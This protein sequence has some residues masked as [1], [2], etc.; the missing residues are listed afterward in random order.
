MPSSTRAHADERRSLERE[1]EHLEVGDAEAPPELGG[2]GGQLARGR[3]V[4]ARVGEVALVEREPAVVG[5]GSSGSSRRCARR[6]QP[7]ATAQAPRKSSSSA[8][9]HVAMR[10]APAASAALP[11][12]PVRALPGGEHGLGVVEPPGRPAQPLERLGRLLAGDG[13]L[14]PRPRGLPAPRAQFAPTR[15]HWIGRPVVPCPAH[16]DRILPRASDHTAIRGTL[17]AARPDAP[18]V[19]QVRDPAGGQR[20]PVGDEPVGERRDG[21]GAGRHADQRQRARQPRL[22]DAEPARA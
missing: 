18:P 22:D 13:L 11:V 5:P 4:A 21:G 10:A 7:L 9:S 3:G 2:R 14:E 12:E 17:T 6:S 16:A 20:E 19:D 8:A 1:A 15:D